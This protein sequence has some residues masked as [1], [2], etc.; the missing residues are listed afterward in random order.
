MFLFF[1][2]DNDFLLEK[3]LNELK[4]KYQQKAGGDLNLVRFNGEEFDYAKFSSEA[5]AM[6]LLATSRL[7]VVKNIFACKSKKQLDMLKEF[8]PK[9]SSSTIVVFTHIGKIDK[10]LG[11]YKTLIKSKNAHEFKELEGS[12]KVKFIKDQVKSLGSEI[13]DDEAR[14]LA[15]YGED[16]RQIYN[17]LCKLSLYRYGKKIRSEDI[18]KLANQSISS[19]IFKMIDY[20]SSNDKKNALRELKKLL[21][22]NESGIKILSMIN[23]QYR[24]ICLIKEGQEKADNPFAVSKIA[25][26]SYFQA[27]NVYQSAKRYS[28]AD[29]YHIYT[30]M[31][32]FD[33]A[34]KTGKISEEEG[35]KELVLQI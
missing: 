30:Q 35:I 32:Y 29:L 11:L 31:E 18:D 22:N 8:L 25:G 26:V 4:D 33:E 21:S 6:P 2:G 12:K 14:M 3:K 9:I 7:I 13:D 17:D 23:Y 20:L 15:D 1:Y 19:D 34:I 28:W 16:L 24:L 27:K 5:Q 10:R